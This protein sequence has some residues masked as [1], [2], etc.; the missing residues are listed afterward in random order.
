MYR[1]KEDK[2]Q[3]EMS[4]SRDESLDKKDSRQEQRNEEELEEKKREKKQK[5]PFFEEH[6]SRE[7]IEEGLANG[8]LFRGKLRINAKKS[9]EG[10]VTV[11][12]GAFG[13]DVLID[14]LKQ[15]NRAIHGDCVAIEIVP[16]DSTDAKDEEEGE[17]VPD[18][19]TDVIFS[20]GDEVEAS[21][22]SDKRFKGKVVGIIERKNIQGMVG[23]LKADDLK[24]GSNQVTFVP[25]DPR[26]P[27]AQ[28]NLTAFG[29]IRPV[30][31]E[32][33]N[34]KEAREK[35]LIE[36]TYLEWKSVQR[37][38]KASFVKII[39]QLGN[40]HAEMKALL[41]RHKVLHT[42]QFPDAALECLRDFGAWDEEKLDIS[43]RL[44]LRQ[45]RIFS[46]DPL[47]ARDLDDALS[48][49]R[50][51]EGRYRVG[52]HIADVSHFVTPGN[53][54]DVEASRRATSVYLMDRVIP[55]LPRLLCENLCSLNPGVSRY[56]FSVHFEIRDDG[57][58]DWSTVKFAKSVIKSCAKLDYDSVQE[59]LDG[60]SLTRQD[61]QIFDQNLE[62]IR[63]DCVMLNNLAKTRRAYRI[64]SG[65][66]NIDSIKLKYKLDENGLPISFSE[67]E[68]TDS[69]LLI[70]EFML[71]ANEMAARVISKSHPET[72]LLRRHEPPPNVD[73]LIKVCNHFGITS[74][75][76]SA[77][78][79]QR[80]A[81]VM[82]QHKCGESQIDMKLVL[83][84]MFSRCM[85]PA[86]YFCINGIDPEHWRHFNLNLASYTHFTSPI[87]RYADLIVH[88]MLANLLSEEQNTPFVITNFCI[89][90]NDRNT[91]CRLLETDMDVLY[92]CHYVKKVPT[93]QT[94]V[95]TDIGKLASYTHFTS[96]I[97]R[98]ADLIVHRMLANLLSEEQNT[99]FVIT[100]FCIN[101]NDRNT[102]CRLLE[103]D[104]DVLYFC[105]YVKKVPT[106]QTAVITDIGK[107]TFRVTV[108]ALNLD[109]EIHLA[110]FKKKSG[111][112]SAVIEGEELSF[113]RQVIVEWDDV[114]RQVLKP[115]QS[116]NVMI[117]MK[118]SRRVAVELFV[119]KPE[120]PESPESLPGGSQ[121]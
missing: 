3:K 86:E 4:S 99:P 11:D 105:H 89:N 36:V 5:K 110:T 78:E 67:Y 106:P 38:P 75:L 47:T 35:T 20:G 87:R 17:D 97:R 113:N 26:M 30:P 13:R 108:L 74:D 69:H 10:Y 40:I 65:C 1:R 72:A 2:R 92:F 45:Q 114:H 53:A 12:G 63:N 120:F 46:I 34:D 112:K 61:I 22:S 33:I 42:D 19:K 28:L 54:L 83:E 111:A 44:D 94:A 117:T 39:G 9:I 68:R 37:W 41:V 24:R 49:S 81:E 101:C 62:D 43:G 71:L 56:A 102:E 90:C 48:I 7:R 64:E 32:L 59:L 96:P 8:S 84:H 118:D 91:E 103:T 66:F 31:E 29:L 76:D 115:F 70:E 93:P 15:R 18:V 88:R 52:V 104:M 16:D 50:I 80:V 73:K 27:L 116:V 82:S 85:K 100:N 25:Q 55:M 58:P 98:Y 21:G 119:L 6:W 57:I 109:G 95:I 51:G 107:L 121:S 77:G 23:W 79:I 14:G 60:K